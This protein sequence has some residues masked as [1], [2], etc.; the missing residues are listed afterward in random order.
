[1]SEGAP[2]PQE[3]QESVEELRDYLAD[4]IPPLLA[5]GAVGALVSGAPD[6]MTAQVQGWL[7]FH[8]RARGRAVAYSDLAFHALRKLHLLGELGL[9]PKE[10]LASY[11]ATLIEAIVPL[12]PPEEQ[13]VVRTS[14]TRLRQGGTQELGKTAFLIGRAPG[15]EMEAP[16]AGAGT[17]GAEL[18]LELRR[19]ALLLERLKPPAAG[20]ASDHPAAAPGEE[21]VAS[22]LAAAATTAR[23]N[24]ELGQYLQHLRELGVQGADPAVVVRTLSRAL[25]DWAPVVAASP[26]ALGGNARALR[27]F[28]DLADGA[29]QRG[30]RFRE[31]VRAVVDEFNSGSLARAVA[32]VQVA[33]SLLAERKVPASDAEL[34]RGSAHEALN[35]ERLR[36][37]A[38]DS[39]QHPLLRQLMDFFPALHPVGLLN[40][41]DGELD[42]ALRRLRLTLLE[43]HGAAARPAILDRIE[44]TRG[45]SR[46]NAWFYQRNLLYLLHRIPC[47]PE[48]L[49]ERELEQVVHFSQLVHHPRLVGEALLRLTQIRHERAEQALLARL[50]EIEAGLE[51]GTAAAIPRDDLERLRSLIAV[52]LLRGGSPAARRAVV[53]SAIGRLRHAGVADRL[54][55]LRTVDLSSEPNLVDGLLQALHALLPRKLLGVVLRRNAEVLTEI[56]QALSATPAPLVRRALEEVVEQFPGEPF[57]IEAS[58][59]LTAFEAAATPGARPEGGPGAAPP[60]APRR[61]EG[62]LRLFGLPNLLQSLAQGAL[63]GTLTLKDRQGATAGAL[64]LRDGALIGCSTARLAGETAFFQLLERPLAT[65]FQFIDSDPAARR[66][67]TA[68]APQEI[69]PLLLEGM[70]R[71]DEYSRARALVPDTT[72]L[73]PTGVR[74][75]TPRGETDGAFVREL[76]GR[77]KGGDTAAACEEALPA[78]AYRIRTLLA[79]WLAEGA[80]AVSLF[81]P[82]AATASPATGSPS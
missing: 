37:V 47:A 53:Q 17:A 48:A 61:M 18:T 3:L 32:L 9:V 73:V 2:S 81:P 39:H 35:S 7:S 71:C 21:L 58:K 19:F 16:A 76:W 25:P 31:L 64:E 52:G 33:A 74:P 22:V 66:P 56:V 78:D 24:A 42:R 36:A 62:D 40:A 5:A 67:A 57:G 65:T 75:T 51:G 41:L 46:A 55:E 20:G 70:R 50:Q 69:L 44:A 1:M 77:V 59:A 68:A 49:E 79:H 6:T 38:V 26:E 10:Q 12:C 15:A 63:S 4:G 82:S 28:V 72:V 11:L 23:S 30:E 8:Y 54:A 45:D 27:R 13:E 60:P 43:I 14:L 34:V 80:V 29:E